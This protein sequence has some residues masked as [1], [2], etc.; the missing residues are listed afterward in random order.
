MPPFPLSAALHLF[1]PGKGHISDKDCSVGICSSKKACL[2]TVALRLSLSFPR[3]CTAASVGGP[4]MRCST[5]GSPQLRRKEEGKATATQ[6][7]TPLPVPSTLLSSHILCIGPLCSQLCVM[8]VTPW[9]PTRVLNSPS[10]PLIPKPS[11]FL[12][13]LRLIH[14]S[15]LQWLLL[16]SLPN[17][18]TVSAP[19]HPSHVPASFLAPSHS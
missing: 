2:S 5:V 15:C 1:L 3:R 16:H 12:L 19:A 10:S 8:P 9:S 18:T 11:C 6:Q 17:S 4:P 13:A 7:Q 14:R